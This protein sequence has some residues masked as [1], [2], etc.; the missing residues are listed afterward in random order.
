MNQP[1]LSN[2]AQNVEISYVASSLNSGTFTAY[3][4]DVMD[5]DGAYVSL[6]T[7]CTEDLTLVGTLKCTVLMTDMVTKMT[8]TTNGAPTSGTY[9]KVVVRTENQYGLGTDSTA[10][11][12]SAIVQ[13]APTAIP[14]RTEGAFDSVVMTDTTAVLTWSIFNNNVENGHSAITTYNLYAVLVSNLTQVVT[15]VAYTT[16]SS[17]TYTFTGLVPN[18]AYRFYIIP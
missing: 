1:T 13:T 6:D 18:N 16:L 2:V 4:L 8:G 11:V 15:P 14:V 10:N 5:T 3:H 9:I 7:S 12:D 17:L